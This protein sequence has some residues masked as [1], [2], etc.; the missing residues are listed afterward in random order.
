MKKQSEEKQ[1]ESNFLSSM[2]FLTFSLGISL[3]VFLSYR[4]TNSFNVDTGVEK[5][6][7]VKPKKVPAHEASK[8]Q[9][10]KVETQKSLDKPSPQSASVQTSIQRASVSSSDKGGQVSEQEAK[11]LVQRAIELV[12]QSE[13]SEAK[14]LLE[15]VLHDNPEHEE[16]LT[17]LALIHLLD[18]KDEKAA[19]P[20]FEKVLSNNP[21]HKTALAE[22]VEIYS[23]R[24]DGSGVKYLENLYEKTPSPKIALGIG[25][26]LIESN[27]K[28]AIPYLEKGGNSALGELAEAHSMNGQYDKAFEV[29]QRQEELLTSKIQSS[30]PDRNGYVKD[31][32]IRVKMNIVSNLNAQG[33]TEQ[34]RNYI[35]S[36]PDLLPFR[37][38][39]SFKQTGYGPG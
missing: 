21:D 31:E 36:D 34:V 35:N 15:K 8:V 18:Y 26:V 14:L 27:P 7:E 2:I 1:I 25:Q 10:A 16:A 9:L 22:L 19:Q 39:L 30:D 32:L 20:L 37:D 6:A 4:P 11:D 3:T 5:L 12:N 24:A 33:K 17:Q 29:L 13:V 28:A 38:H 23:D